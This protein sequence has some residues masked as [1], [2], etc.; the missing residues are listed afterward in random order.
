[1]VTT[2]AEHSPAYEA[3]LA[4]MNIGLEEWRD[5]IGYDLGALAKV[6]DS[7]RVELVVLMGE[8]LK[9]HP[10]WREVEALGAV[11]TPA[12]RAILRAARKRVD[13]E[14]RMHIEE[15][16]DKLEKSSGLE[17]AIIDALRRTTMTS[18]LSRAIDMAEENPTPRI[19]KTLLDVALN[20][21]DD[22]GRVNCAAL[23]LYLGGKADEAF[24]WNHRP[25]FLRFGEEDRKVRV[26]AYRELCARLG[27]EPKGI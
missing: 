2:M 27:V 26:E 7:E 11:G 4:S 16:L 18:G 9:T 5:G 21:A 10:D 8:R 13:P 22:V 24:D 12:A 6:T 1:M 25:F 19:R 3:F 23:A 20:G 17:D 14:T 15:H